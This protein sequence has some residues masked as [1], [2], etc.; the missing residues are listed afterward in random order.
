MQGQLERGKQ[1]VDPRSGNPVSPAMIIGIPIGRMMTLQ[2]RLL[3]LGCGSHKQPGFIG[4]DYYPF[5]GV[6]IVRDLRRGLPFDDCT[7][8]EIIA[9]Q[10]LEHFDGDDLIFIVE[11]CWRV[12][13][14]G[15]KILV[16]VPDK[17]SAN[18][19]KDFTHKKKD[20]DEWSFQMWMKRDGKYLIDRGPLYRIQGEF[21]VSTGVNQQTW[22]RYYSLEVV[23][24][25]D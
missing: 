19:G 5:T 15:A 23:K 3:D 6:D 14:P 7:V 20:W 17:T 24:Q 8:D 10:V 12:C 2:S 25:H 4:I 18:A 21:L 9:K 22:D 1:V 11:E 13:K 16:I